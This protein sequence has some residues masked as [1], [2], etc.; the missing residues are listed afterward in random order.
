[1]QVFSLLF[2]A[3][4]YRFFFYSSRIHEAAWI[5]SFCVHSYR[6][7]YYFHSMLVSRHILLPLFL[8]KI[9]TLLG[10]TL[11]KWRNF[12]SSKVCFVIMTY[13]LFKKMW[14][15]V[16]FYFSGRKSLPA[17]EFCSHCSILISYFH[18][19]FP[20]LIEGLN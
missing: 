13:H 10:G 7:T 5:M 14:E 4:N 8:W 3:W 17:I 18:L 16:V 15:W 12:K 2:T 11:V 20:S 1:M 19:G 6:H 9:V